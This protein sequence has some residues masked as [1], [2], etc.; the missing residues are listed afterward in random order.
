MKKTVSIFLSAVVIIS[1]VLFTFTGCGSK[2]EEEKKPESGTAVLDDFD[3]SGGWQTT[4]DFEAVE[5]PE[6]ARAAFDKATEE[7]D[8]AEYDLAAYLGSQVVAGTNYAYLCNITTVT[9]EPKT[10]LNLVT[11]YEDLEGTARITHT[12]EVDITEYTTEKEIAFE[13][14]PGGWNNE[15][16]VGGK[17]SDDAQTA[18]DKALEGMTGVAYEPL[19]LLGTQVVAGTNY[20]VLCKATSVTAEPVSKLAVL[21]VY[22]DLQTNAQVLSICSVEF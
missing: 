6:A 11:V 18:F 14:I 7:L 20:A 4:T 22:A 16:A 2:N 19:A 21:V 15:D 5:I 13:N 17:I 12:K 1:A 10:K 9:A 3:I 8:G